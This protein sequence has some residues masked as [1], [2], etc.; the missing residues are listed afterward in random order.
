MNPR[1]IRRRNKSLGAQNDA[2]A[3]LVTELVKH[4]TNI[5][6]GIGLN[7]FTSPAGKHFI[8][9][10]VMVMLVVTALMMVMMLMLA[11]LMMIVLAALMMVM[12][13]MLMLAALVVIV[14]VAVM[15]GSGGKRV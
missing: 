3:R 10:V 11:A 9:V 15:L 13:V 8:R 1:A 7:R 4:R 5:L 2:K 14:L 12:M 6:F